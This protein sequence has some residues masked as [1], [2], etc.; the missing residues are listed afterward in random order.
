MGEAVA[1]KPPSWMLVAAAHGADAALDRPRQPRLPLLRA[2][3]RRGLPNLA[4][5]TLVPAILFFVV[6]TTVSAAFAM[7]AVLVWAYTAILRRVVRGRGSL[8]FCSWRPSG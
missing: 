4:E 1:T 7:G 2:V 8:R 6:L 5:S 3:A